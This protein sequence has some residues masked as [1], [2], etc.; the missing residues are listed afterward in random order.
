MFRERGTLGALRRVPLGNEMTAHIPFLLATQTP[1]LPVTVQ[2]DTQQYPVMSEKE[3]YAAYDVRER[4]YWRTRDDLVQKLFALDPNNERI[5]KILPPCWAALGQAT[6]EKEI[7]DFLKG[8]PPMDVEALARATRARFQLKALPPKHS[9]SDV[10]AIWSDMSAHCLYSSQAPD[11]LYACTRQLASRVNRT[12]EFRILAQLYP[13]Y[14]RLR[15]VK[16]YLKDWSGKP[17]FELDFKE[18]CTKKTDS[19]CLKR[20]HVILVYFTP[21]GEPPQPIR[22][23]YVRYHDAGLEAIGIA[24]VAK[25]APMPWPLVSDANSGVRKSWGVETSPTVF[26]VD[27]EGCL[28]YA[29]PSD[30]EGHVKELMAQR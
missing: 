1:A 27:K 2:L 16:E 4:A 11:V 3:T 26:L 6:A 18:V 23:L 12:R 7:H 9:D 10:M 20:G 28:A 21:N 13:G 29:N 14:E 24:S 5:P 15:E 25:P 19:V 22:D 30:I 8:S 17:N